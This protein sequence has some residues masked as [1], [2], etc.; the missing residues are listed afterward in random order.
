MK[1]LRIFQF[2]ANGNFFQPKNKNRAALITLTQLGFPK[3]QVR[4]ALI[5]LNG[6]KYEDIS[7]DTIRPPLIS[8]TVKGHTRN[9]EAQQAISETL[10][11]TTEELF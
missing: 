2:I 1:I 3:S 6:I 10:G 4:R 7:S 8:R 11:L 5:E 9:F